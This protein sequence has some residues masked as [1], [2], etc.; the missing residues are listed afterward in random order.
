MM[1]ILLLLVATIVVGM[2]YGIGH[3]DQFVFTPEEMQRYAAEA[4]AETGGEDAEKVGFLVTSGASRP[5]LS[6]NSCQSVLCSP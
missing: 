3:E 4:I 5:C 1:K 2:Y 6:V